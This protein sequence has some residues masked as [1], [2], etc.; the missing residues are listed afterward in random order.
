MVE[1]VSDTGHFVVTVLMKLPQSRPD[2]PKLLCSFWLA[3]LSDLANFVRCI[4][5]LITAEIMPGETL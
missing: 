4:T 5:Y 2:L 3:S 1:E